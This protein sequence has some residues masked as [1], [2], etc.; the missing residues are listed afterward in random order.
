MPDQLS[1]VPM[2]EEGLT[3]CETHV[4]TEFGKHPD[5][6]DSFVEPQPLL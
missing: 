1:N 2:I 6:I 4:R 3:S 5:I